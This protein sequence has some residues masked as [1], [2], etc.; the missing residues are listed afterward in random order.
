MNN[1]TKRLET[2]RER[3]RAD[4]E[5]GRKAALER[6]KQAITEAKKEPK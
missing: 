2:E 1:E 5:A 4:A 6:A 3:A